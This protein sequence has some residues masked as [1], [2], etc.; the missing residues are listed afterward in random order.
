MRTLV[1]CVL[2]L[3]FGLLTACPRPPT[4]QWLKEERHAV[5]APVRVLQAAEKVFGPQRHTAAA[6]T[7][8]RR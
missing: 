1:N 8:D 3:N 4:A 7:R 6:A 5:L 2:G